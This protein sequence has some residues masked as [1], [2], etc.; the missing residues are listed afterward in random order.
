MHRNNTGLTL[1]ELIVGL[2]IIGILTGMAAPSFN[3]IIGRNEAASAINWIIR[4]VLFTR[5]SALTYGV[6]TTLCPSEDGNTCGGNWHDGVLIFTDANGDRS[7]ND[8]DRK[9]LRLQYPYS[10][11]TIKWRSFRNR[12]Y[13]QITGMGYTHS[14]NGNFVFCSEDRDPQFS[15]Q[16]VINVQGRV[17]KSYDH[18]NDGLVED[19]YN[20]LLRC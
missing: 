18:D 9:L 5:Q 1:I 17:R 7:I 19:R 4:S 13:L 2:A 10:G 16:I 8:H 14:Q 11:S 12:Q 3:R 6:L 15:R 20:E